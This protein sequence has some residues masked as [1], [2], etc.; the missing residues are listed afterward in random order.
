MLRKNLY[1]DMQKNRSV[2]R[3][4]FKEMVLIY[5]KCIQLLG[6]LPCCLQACSLW[7]FVMAISEELAHL[8]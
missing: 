1:S 2:S 8:V 3:V 5:S 6:S 4:G 7:S